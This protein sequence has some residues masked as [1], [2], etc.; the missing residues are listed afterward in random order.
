MEKTAS[1]RFVFIPQGCRLVPSYKFLPVVGF[2][3]SWMAFLLLPKVIQ[4]LPVISQVS[5]LT[6]GHHLPW[7]PCPGEGASSS[8]I[9]HCNALSK[10]CKLLQYLAPWSSSIYLFIAVSVPH[11]S[12]SLCVYMCVNVHMPWSGCAG[13]RTTWSWCSPSTT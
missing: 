9:T 3:C 11:P 2:Q 6:S 10:M 13:Q 5:A 1:F 8:R 7:G 12:L 4:N